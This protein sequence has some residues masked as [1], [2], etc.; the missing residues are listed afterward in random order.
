MT[1]PVNPSTFLIQQI[2]EKRESPFRFRT[3]CTRIIKGEGLLG[4]RLIIKFRRDE[5]CH[6]PK[7]ICLAYLKSFYGGMEKL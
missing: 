3:R 1:V 4:D 5:S 2:L 6:C 7:N